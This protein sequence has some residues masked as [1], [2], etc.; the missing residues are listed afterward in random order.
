MHAI[1]LRAAANMA[2]PVLVVLTVALFAVAGSAHG[3]EPDPP[4]PAPA[5]AADNPDEPEAQA[6]RGTAGE[7]AAA[8]E[9][10]AEP[11]PSTVA[12]TDEEIPLARRS[13]SEKWQTFRRA[14]QGLLVWDLFDGRVTVRSHARVMVDGTTGWGDDR[15]EGVY[16][17]PDDSLDIRRLS[18]FAQGIID[19]RMRYSLSFEFGPDAGLGEAFVEGREEGLDLFGYRIGQ[20]RLGFFQEPFGLERVMSSY[21]S[22]FL[23][24]ALPIWTFAPGSNVGYM[25]FDT[26]FDQRM[27]WSV[28]FFSFGQGN[29]ANSSQSSLS[30]TSRV[31]G[32]PVYG[33]DGRRVLHVGA[34][35]STRDPRSGSVRYRSRPEAR[36]ADFLVDTGDIAAGRIQLLGV[37][38]LGMAG[39]FHVQ[40]EA[41]MSSLQQ[42]EYG[43]LDL[44][45]F[46]VE[47]GWF[48]TGEHRAYDRELG[49]FSRM[50]PTTEFHGGLG[51]LFRGRR[52][53][54]L[55]VVGRLSMVDLNDEELRGGELT[56]LSLGLNWYW[57]STS[58][59]KLNY[60]SSSV[61][62]RGRV[63]I[64]LL[65][66][67]YRPLPIPGW[68]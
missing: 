15:Y 37:E 41:V 46:Y 8:E 52:G 60:I 33:E 67:Q 14:T 21:Y 25:L 58:I 4:G 24:R 65:R 6:A 12:L 27:Q 26:A 13:F 62:D 64:V 7:N 34:S 18:L 22:S 2:A 40:A 59:V 53:G 3:S 23:E 1:R 68:R 36:F 30:L 32:L 66:Y 47:A 42:T 54:A 61:E 17:V 20:F 35:F 44:W 31:S 5:P 51:G 57:S 16:G 45:G 11:E 38:A 49:G 9:P 56:N 10:A 48:I 19:H 29:E 43:D 55:E 50:V 39:P 63:N 28:G